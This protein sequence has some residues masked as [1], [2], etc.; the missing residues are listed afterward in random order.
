MKNLTRIYWDSIFFQKKKWLNS[1][2]RKAIKEVFWKMQKQSSAFCFHA[3]SSF[4]QV[5]ENVCSPA[6]KWE[7]PP[8]R[9]GARCNVFR[10]PSHFFSR[11]II[12]VEHRETT[13]GDGSTNDR[14][15]RRR[16]KRYYMTGCKGYRYYYESAKRSLWMFVWRLS[17]CGAALT[18]PPWWCRRISRSKS[19]WSLWESRRF[20]TANIPA[21]T[22]PACESERQ[23]IFIVKRFISRIN[24]ICDRR[25]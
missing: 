8:T 18:A 25:D 13:T 2:T 1:T 15:G 4:L 17:W 23:I 16:G 11:I 6:E 7:T 22:S 20:R 21:W 3:G 9:Q 5:I 10:G 14:S 12:A 19:W 24:I